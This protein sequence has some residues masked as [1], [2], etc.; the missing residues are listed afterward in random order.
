LSRAIQAVII[1]NGPAAIQGIEGLRGAGFKG[2]IKL[3]SD[4]DSPGYHPMLLPYYIG[5]MIKRKGMFIC[6]Q[7]FYRSHGVER[8]MG[9][10][11]IG[12]DVKRQRV[13][14]ERKREVPYDLLLIATGAVPRSPEVSGINLQNVFFVRKLREAQRI[15]RWIGG[16]KAALVVGASLIGLKLAEVLCEKGV[17][18]ELID[19]ADQILPQNADSECAALMQLKIEKEGIPLFL[20][21]EMQGISPFK[22]RLMV[23]FSSGE[24]LYTDMVVFCLGTH[25]N[26]TVVRGA[27]I[28]TNRG[29]LVDRHLRTNVENIYAAGDV[30]EGNNLLTGKTENI[31]NSLNACIQGLMAGMNMAGHQEIFEGSIRRNVTSLFGMSFASL[32]ELHPPWRRGFEIK[33]SSPECNLYRKV[34]LSGSRITGAIL[35]NDTNSVGIMSRAIENR[36]DIGDIEEGL[37]R[38]SSKIE[39]VLLPLARNEWVNE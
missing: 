36:Y 29:I 37:R 4:E 7:R 5:G 6:D 10:K 15:K 13:V 12:L 26:T 21:R 9:Q 23:S 17:R 18:V 22:G 11:A 1:G 16:G 24:K 38:Y 2:A 8:R 14:L 28:K 20:A 19:I 35:L 32:G 27:P 3:I 33:W 25:P 39:E 34:I 31:P 30:T